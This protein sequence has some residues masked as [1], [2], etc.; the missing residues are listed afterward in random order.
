M[1]LSLHF[2]SIL[3]LVNFETSNQFSPLSFKIYGFS[4]FNQIL[5]SLFDISTAFYNSI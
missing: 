2:Y 4:H 5:L 1:F 3:E